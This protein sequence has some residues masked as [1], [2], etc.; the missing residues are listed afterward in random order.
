MVG[1]NDQLPGH[2]FSANESV[3][4]VDEPSGKAEAVGIG[5]TQ[6]TNNIILES[7]SLYP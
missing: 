1:Y 2:W 4:S 5:S 7:P 3:I 6:G